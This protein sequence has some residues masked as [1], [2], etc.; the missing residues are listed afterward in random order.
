MIAQLSSVSVEM[1]QQL[2]SV[3]LQLKEADY[4]M[5]L[6]LLN[7]NSIGKHIRHVYE[8]FDEMMAGIQSR[9][10]NYD[11][12][13]R[14]LRIEREPIYACNFAA[15]LTDKLSYLSSDETLTLK[16]GY[17]QTA[18]VVVETSLG[19]ELA[20]NIEHAIH[21]MAIIQ[22]CIKHYFSYVQLDENFGVAFST[23]KYLQ[24]NVYTN[25][26]A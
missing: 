16:G 1:I 12:R 25:L 15:G 17:G 22:I 20:Y 14:N 11:A 4:A 9:E 3:S 13:K 19:R 5:P 18:D 8:L 21:H 26:P 24:E 7:G 2:S 6:D 10:I 23:Q